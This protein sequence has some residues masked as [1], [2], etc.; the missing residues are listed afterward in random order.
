MGVVQH[1]ESLADT[2]CRADVNAKPG[3][4]LLL[5]EDDFSHLLSHLNRVTELSSNRHWKS[6]AEGG[7]VPKPALNCYLAAQRFD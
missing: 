2:G 6:E 5:L 7:A 3:W 1:V 4:F